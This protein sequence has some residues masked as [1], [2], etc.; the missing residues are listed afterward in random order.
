MDDHKIF[1]PQDTKHI[2]KILKNKGYESY[3]VGGCVRDSLINREP[4]DWDLTT[5]ALPEQT[6][7]I[8]KTEGFRVIE[9]GIK[10]GTVTILMNG[11]PYEVTTY[12]VDGEY[13]DNR[14]PDN[15]TFTTSLKEDLS[16]RD[17]T[18][19][20][21]AYNEDKGLIDYFNGISDLKS[22]IIRCVGN[23]DERFNE[24][25]LRMLRAVRFSSELEFKLDFEGTFSAIKKNCNLIRNISVERIREEFCKIL[26]SHKPSNGVLALKETNLLEY[27]LPEIVPCTGFN[28]HNVHHDKDI[29][30]H[31]LSV[32]DNAPNNI[33]IRLAALL[34][35]IGKPKCFTMDDK[36]IG[37]FYG[38][39]KVSAEI[40]RKIL[41]RLK[42]D[43]KTIDTVYLLIYEHM[44][45]FDKIKPYSIKKFMNR[46]KI[47]NLE[48]L[49]ELQIADIKGLAEEYR[50]YSKI[51]SLKDKCETIIKEKQP[52]NMKDL[53]INGS[54]LI[55][56]GIKQGKQIGEILEA[57]LDRVLQ[58]TELNNKEKLLNLVY[59]EYI[60]KDETGK[61]L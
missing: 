59:D 7:E 51:L 47:E 16:R 22:K 43:N 21:M 36:N 25:A 14:H 40:A 49:F 6:L 39:N 4:K 37:H 24:D 8:F 23:A 56:L 20:S 2:M 15:V 5:N 61:K 27:I 48:S 18:I 34:H 30:Y 33:N 38:H 10:H 45:K 1:I 44:S 17:F 13:L 26:I 32:L 55:N 57:L 50:D 19:N 12:R 54:D 11:N 42:F 41:V 60:N 58:N 31:T 46:V 3:V 52:L 28:Q 9:T 35:D 29:F 53:N